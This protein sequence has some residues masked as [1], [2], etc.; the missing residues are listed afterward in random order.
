M[1]I[2]V[3]MAGCA[4]DDAANN[5]GDRIADGHDMLVNAVMLNNMTMLVTTMA[6]VTTLMKTLTTKI[7]SRML[8]RSRENPNTQPKPLHLA[9]MC[10]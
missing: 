4:G 6:A 1:P 2:K 9:S 3:V 7:I 5:D 8:M 10:V